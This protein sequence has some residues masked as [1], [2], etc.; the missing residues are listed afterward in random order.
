VTTGGPPSLPLILAR[1]LASNLATPMFLIDSR[2][3]LVFYN[4]AAERLIGRP[5]AELGE[6]DA[7]EW[8]VLLQMAEPDGTPARMRDTPASVAFAERRPSHRVF[9]ATGLDGVRRRVEVTAFPLFATAD[10]LQGVVNVFWEVAPP[11]GE[12]EDDD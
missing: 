11:E 10:D 1:E 3:M 8:G 6:M 2:G 9:L 4:E 7:H 5:F 12:S